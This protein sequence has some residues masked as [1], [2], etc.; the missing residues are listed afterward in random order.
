MFTLLI[1]ISPLSPVSSPSFSEDLG[2]TGVVV[3]LEGVLDLLLVPLLGVIE[4]VGPPLFRPLRPATLLD[5]ALDPLPGLLSSLPGGKLVH[6]EAGHL[7]FLT[8]LEVGP[9]SQGAV[10]GQV[11]A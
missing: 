7:E 2:P 3:L 1:P 6:D 8:L 4:V 10:L 5:D 11:I 9:P